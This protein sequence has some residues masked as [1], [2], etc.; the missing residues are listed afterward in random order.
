MEGLVEIIKY[1]FSSL[2]G[3]NF[4]L[5]TCVYVGTTSVWKLDGTV[6]CFQN[7]QG[8]AALFLLF[9]AIP[10]SF[11][12]A[13]G[14]K[15][16]KDGKISSVH[17]I[18]SCILPLPFCILWLFLYICKWRKIKHLPRGKLKHKVSKLTDTAQVILD[19]LQGPYR[20]DDETVINIPNFFFKGNANNKT[21]PTNQSKMSVLGSAVYWEGIM[22]FRRL[23]LNCLIL[24]DYDIIRQTF[25]TVRGMSRLLGNA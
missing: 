14:T 16:L 4:S 9:Y 17:F 18:F 1:T 8:I 2:A 19:V 7:W 13:L 12:L 11:S 25:D 24:V 23:I 20:D 5:L 10:F 22:E 21:D 15:L 3:S 6:T